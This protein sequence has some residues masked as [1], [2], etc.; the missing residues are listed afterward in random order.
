KYSL[1]TDAE[2]I[3]SASRDAS[4]NAKGL[5]GE[6]VQRLIGF[7]LIIVAISSCYATRIK[8]ITSLAGVRDNQ[9]IGYGLVVGLD[10]TGD[11]TSQAP[12]TDQSFRN[13]LLDFGIRLPDRKNFQ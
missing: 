9:L 6:H 4:L 10:G 5:K 13:M 3:S 8:D 2:N 11:R 1:T 12:F 7:M